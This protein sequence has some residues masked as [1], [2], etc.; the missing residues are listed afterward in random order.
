MLKRGDPQRSRLQLE[1][2]QFSTST[3]LTPKQTEEE[4]AVAQTLTTWG[5]G[6]MI[7]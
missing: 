6:A 5:S 1:I 4:I 7:S 3:G 2:L